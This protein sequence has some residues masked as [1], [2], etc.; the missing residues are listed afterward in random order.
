MPRVQQTCPITKV[1]NVPELRATLFKIGHLYASFPALANLGRTCQAF[2]ADISGD[3]VSV[4][5]PICSGDLSNLCLQMCLDTSSGRFRHLDKSDAEM[6]A[7]VQRGKIS[8]EERLACGAAP[9]LAVMPVRPR[10]TKT[11]DFVPNRWNAA[12]WYDPT[13]LVYAP[14]KVT[15]Q[16]YSLQ[17]VC[18]FESVL[19]LSIDVD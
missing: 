11:A 16:L 10:L 6:D 2:F 14:E 4:P 8:Q 9:F 1:W 15:Q 12:G 5:V 3:I 18:K 7:L 13:G 19:F 17:Q